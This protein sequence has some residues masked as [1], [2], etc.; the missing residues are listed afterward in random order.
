MELRH[1]H[2]FASVAREGQFVRAAQR[3]HVAQSALSQQIR[4]LEREVGAELLIRDR[5][6]I[7]LTPAGA[8]L[9]R[10]ATRILAAVDDARAELQQL[11]GLLAGRLHVGAGAPTGPVRLAH[12]LEGFRAAH[13]GI[14]VM[15][16]DA[17]TGELLRRLRAG[18][19]DAAIVS[20][21]PERLDG[22]LDGLLIARE[23]FVALIPPA[24]R[25]AARRR[26]RLA[27]LNREPI[28]TYARGT[29]IRAAVDAA[30][31]DTGIAPAIAAETMDSSMLLDLVRHGLGIAIVPRSFAELTGDLPAVHLVGTSLE[32]PRTLAWARE[33][34][35]SP[36]LAAFLDFAPAV[37][38]VSR[39]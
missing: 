15:V 8:V 17:S 13:P 32:R 5:R 21:V 36:A 38:R 29:G 11:T 37:L 22:D 26:L 20:E 39:A 10:H 2:Y 28:V 33:R 18:E 31:A 4:M 30:L 23:R 24:H 19:L 6:G 35:A 27:E 3:L 9:Q 16:S 34:R 25:L 14:E 12:A 7:R 1:L